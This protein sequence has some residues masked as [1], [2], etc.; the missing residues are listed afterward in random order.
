MENQKEFQ[1]VKVKY[2]DETYD[3]FKLS[4]LSILDDYQKEQIDIK[5]SSNQKTQ[6]KFPK[7]QVRECD[8][9]VRKGFDITLSKLR[10]IDEYKFD[11]GSQDDIKQLKI[12]I[13][14]Y[15]VLCYG[16]GILQKQAIKQLFEYIGKIQK[17]KQLEEKQTL[18]RFWQHVVEFQFDKNIDMPAYLENIPYQIQENSCYIMAD[19]IIEEDN[20]DKT[21]IIDKIFDN[22]NMQFCNQ[23]NTFLNL[24]NNKTQKQQYNQN[25][26]NLVHKIKIYQS[27]YC[28]QNDQL[29]IIL[30]LKPQENR[31]VSP[32]KSLE[33]LNLNHHLDSMTI[34]SQEFSFVQDWIFSILY[35]VLFDFKQQ[36]NQGNN[37]AIIKRFFKKII[38]NQNIKKNEE[39]II[40]TFDKIKY[41]RL[42]LDDET[43]INMQTRKII[44]ILH[45]F[46]QINKQF[47]KN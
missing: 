24:N 37:Q 20:L 35:K 43:S 8:D 46:T 34:N 47:L 31:Q 44:Q 30:F 26:Q 29:S 27:I 39:K 18:L 12:N 25:F 17:I 22:L 38:N 33:I 36:Y 1:T 7:F 23:D 9:T 13:M 32:Q 6:I 10:R 4:D 42:Q 16:H 28:L 5:Y 15:V 41:Q 14:Y 21:Q 19:I 40:T 2:Y 45:Y 3:S 11:C